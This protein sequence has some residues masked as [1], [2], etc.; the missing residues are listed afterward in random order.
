MK[1][2]VSVNQ[3]KSDNNAYLNVIGD[4]GFVGVWTYPFDDGGQYVRIARSSDG[5]V[6]LLAF[7]SKEALDEFIE[8]SV[9]WTMVDMPELIEE[10]D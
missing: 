2:D 9:T 1:H 5:H 8:T 6:A 3:L 7:G 4:E 10:P